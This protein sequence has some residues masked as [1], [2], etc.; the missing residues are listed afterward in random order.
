MITFA[1]HCVTVD[2]FAPDSYRRSR[3]SLGQATRC[4]PEVITE[5][6]SQSIVSCRGDP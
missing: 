4:K 6:R 3:S 1:Q 2:A 5:N